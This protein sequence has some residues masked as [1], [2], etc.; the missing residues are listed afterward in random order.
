M[1]MARPGTHARF[2]ALL[3]AALA[4]ASCDPYQRYD[5]TPNDS[6][7]PVDPVSFPPANL[8]QR[9]DRSRP[10]QGSFTAAHALAGGARADY[11]A[12]PLPAAQLMA[13]DP[14]DAKALAT[15]AAY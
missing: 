10:G 14:L 7:G 6:L 3:L 5:Q 9:G 8:G 13:M 1:I 2:Y 4:G 12:Y 11:F 15:P